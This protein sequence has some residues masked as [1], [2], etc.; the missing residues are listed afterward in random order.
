[1]V[2]WQRDEEMGE[3]EISH[4]LSLTPGWVPALVVRADNIFPPRRLLVG[5]HGSFHGR[6][7]LKHAVLFWQLRNAIT[8]TTITRETK[9]WKI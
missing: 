3:G 7:L 1:M 5:K 2:D 4:F 8:I 6:Y 9:Q